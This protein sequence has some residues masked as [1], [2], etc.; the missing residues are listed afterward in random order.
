MKIPT[1]LEEM[2]AG[3]ISDERKE[4]ERVEG[5]LSQIHE[6]TEPFFNQS[7]YDDNPMLAEKERALG[8][9]KVLDPKS[10]P[11]APV[12]RE[13]EERP[14]PLVNARSVHAAHV[15]VDAEPVQELSDTERVEN[16]T[17]A[18]ERRGMPPERARDAAEEACG[19]RDGSR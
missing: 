1:A 6:L 13:P 5:I 9:G 10:S 14:A 18:F 19:L 17:K 11:D 3:L 8:V 12:Y 7:I 4:R 16:F 15:P 2:V